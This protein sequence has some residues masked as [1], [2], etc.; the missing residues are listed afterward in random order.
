MPI[1][2]SAKK[3]IRKTKKRTE[4]NLVVKNRV[5]RLVKQARKLIAEGKSKEVD[6]AIAA[7]SK[8][9]DKAAQ[10]KVLHK[11]KAARIKSRLHKAK[12]SKK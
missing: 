6:K 2:K 11:K 4:R 3:Y 8:Q 9:L 5:K 12:K 7:A 1:K 10:K